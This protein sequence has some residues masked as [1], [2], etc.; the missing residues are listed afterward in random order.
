MQAIPTYIKKKFEE[1]LRISQDHGTMALASIAS[2]LEVSKR[3]VL[4][5]KSEYH[6]LD[7]VYECIMTNIEA[8]IVRASTSGY[9]DRGW[10]QFALVSNHNWSKEIQDVPTQKIELIGADE[11]DIKALL[12]NV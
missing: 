10:T 1:A 5:N 6:E 11:S 4:R 3:W 8:N 12:E 7:E 2:E 9:M